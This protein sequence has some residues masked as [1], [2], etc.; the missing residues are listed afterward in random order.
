LTLIAGFLASHVR[1]VDIEPFRYFVTPADVAAMRWI[2]ENTPPDALFAV[3]T[4]F[5]LPSAP[6]GTDA[7]Y[8]IPYFTGRSMTAGVMLLSLA[9]QEYVKDTITRSQAVEELET[10]SESLQSLSNLGVDYIYVGKKGDFSG[11]GLREQKLSETDGTE[12]V[13]QRS[14]VYIFK[15]STD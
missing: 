2:E 1:T 3:N 9:E 12:L 13:Y 8:W 7:G 5:W 14:G 15:L 4:Y 11:P 6:H 10:D